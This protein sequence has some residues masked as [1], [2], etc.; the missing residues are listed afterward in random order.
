MTG[1]T[2][3]DCRHPWRLMVAVLAFA[4]TLL[5]ARSVPAADLAIINARV[6]TGTHSGVIENATILVTGD[7]IESVSASRS[8][9]EASVID[10]RGMTALSGLVDAH[11]H[12]FFDLQD[13]PYFPTSDTEAQTYV[14]RIREKLQAHLEHGFTTILSP[15]DFWPQIIEVRDLVAA[16][17]FSGPRLFV[18]GGVFVAPG[19]HYVCRRQREDRRRWCDEHISWVAADPEQVRNGVRRYADSGVDV[20]VYDSVTNAP[21]PARDVVQALVD[22]A[23]R[24]DLP[25]LV[26]GSD[27]ARFNGLI[28]AGVDAFVHPPGGK[29]ADDGTALTAFDAGKA[30]N[31][32]IA[33][34]IGE[35]KEAI[36]LGERS[37]EEVA[38]YEATRA[39]ILA[40]LKEGALP[41]LG[42]D[43]PGTDPGRGL[44]IALRALL[45]LGLSN[46]EIL[47]ASTAHPA[48]ALLGQREL[49]TIE[50]GNFADILIVNGNPLDDVMAL[51]NVIVVI[52]GGS[53][54][55]DNR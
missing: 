27:I 15:I 49:G 20:I 21:V 33:I 51:R 3:S 8:T 54:V 43:M 40:L 30:K 46:E 10:A 53:V 18:G 23:H 44:P 28:E 1:R 48:R 31:I 9:G 25:V 14:E 47:Q 36:R 26:H 37:Q 24:H 17:D 35:T 52:K 19:G 39:S 55:V 4:I 16:G 11:V 34:T 12:L 7:R 13:E 50:P 38:A 2:P 29:P 45:D 22:E 32:P 41:V 42:T 6:F 5:A